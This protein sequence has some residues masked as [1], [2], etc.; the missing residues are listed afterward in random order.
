ME[1]RKTI[2]DYLGKIFMTFGIS[3]VAVMIFT[4][5]VGDDAGTIS[6]MFLLGGEG[7]AIE[8]MLQY[9]ILSALII[10]IRYVFFTDSLI[11]QMPLV[12]RTA[13]MLVSVITVIVGFVICFH[14]FPANEWRAW[15]MFV[16]CFACCFLVSVVV[17]IINHRENKKMEEGLSRMQKQWKEGQEKGERQE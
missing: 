1:E 8:T 16:V 11:K 2:F 13:G 3:M 6:D 9:L 5:L 7:V 15:V 10:G 14:W 17:T 4:W 12:A